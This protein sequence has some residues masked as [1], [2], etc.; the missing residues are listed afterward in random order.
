MFVALSLYTVLQLRFD[1]QGLDILS[2]SHVVQCRIVVAALKIVACSGLDLCLSPMKDGLSCT[3]SIYRFS[4][5][6]KK[7]KNHFNFK[8]LE[9]NLTL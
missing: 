2:L 7:D 4:F 9:I 3:G 8:S 6:N 1:T 5:D